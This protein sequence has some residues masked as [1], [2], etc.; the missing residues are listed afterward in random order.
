MLDSRIIN[1]F[2]LLLSKKVPGLEPVFA[3]RRD[4]WVSYPFIE[5]ELGVDA[6]FALRL[7][8]DLHRLGY[9][10]REFYDKVQFCPACNSQALRLIT[11]CIKCASP[12]L[13]RQQMLVHKRCNYTAPERVFL[14]GSGRSCP[15][16]RRELTLIGDDYDRAG[17]QFECQTCGEL[18]AA[19]GEKWHCRDCGRSYEKDDVRELVMYRYLPNHAQLAQ[20]R[21]QRI[22]KAKV[23]EC[24]VREG[25]EIQEDV[26]IIGR[27][28]AEHR[29]DM[30]AAKRTG[31][32]EHRIVV[33]FAS[34]EKAVDSEEVIKLYAKAYDVNAQDIILIAAPKL[35]EDALQ[36]AEHYHIKVYSAD[37]LDRFDFPVPI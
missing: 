8:D 23:R 16:C 36:F 14:R 20:L 7:L 28:G 18:M 5:K 33:G 13:V 2:E 26:H 17:V 25:Y 24:L 4:S 30:L 1:F 3:P 6:E 31:P 21:A 11:S 29:L 22:P 27:S 32:L 35:A 19:P 34:A 15:K 10:D 37:A 9:L 12:N